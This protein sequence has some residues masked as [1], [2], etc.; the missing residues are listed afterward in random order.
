[1]NNFFF[2]KYIKKFF[3]FLIV[4]LSYILP[5]ISEPGVSVFMYHR[6]GEHKYPSTNISKEQ[7]DAHIEY[8]LSNEIK[9]IGLDELI[10]ALDKNDNF[11]KKT[12]A[13][14]VDDAY[15]SFYK[16]AWPVFRDNQIPVTLFI[17][18]DI[19]DKKTKGYMTWEDI[20][21]FIDEGGSV[22]QHTSTHLH[23][24]LNNI[25][26]LKKDILNSHKSWVKN[27]GFIPRLFAY[28]YGETSNEVISLLE[29][30][31]ISHAFGQHSGVI[32]SFDNR[33][34]LPRFSL[35][36]R[37]G[38][39]DR[40]EFAVNAHSLNIENFLP[41]DMFLTNNKKPSIEFTIINNLKNNSLDCFSNPGGIWGKQEV[42]NIKKN[43]VKILLNESYLTGRARL[44]C[45]TKVDGKWYWFGYQFL[46]K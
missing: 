32:S 7:F 39:K 20:K 18:T 15:S 14:S 4:Y 36:E 19:I 29:E 16:I 1:M 23:M 8:I 10:V 24:P 44:N 43:R 46:V 30:F 37:F 11:D 42:I 3:L 38:S 5:A 45:T 17:S 6:F 22:G 33:Y 25:S 28:P 35:N 21:K 27:I 40:F 31:N 34:Y 2:T 41:G 13:F 26:D 9:V 12:V